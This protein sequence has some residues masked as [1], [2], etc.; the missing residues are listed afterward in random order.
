MNEVSKTS[1]ETFEKFVDHDRY[2]FL[3][4]ICKIFKQK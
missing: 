2:I 1:D 3:V 4:D